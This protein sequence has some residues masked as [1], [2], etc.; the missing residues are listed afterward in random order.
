[1]VDR[2]FEIVEAVGKFYSVRPEEGE[3]SKLTIRNLSDTTFIS[4]RSCIDVVIKLSSLL[5][6][7][8]YGPG[9]DMF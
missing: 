8:V 1:M 7:Y 9:E 4:E 3:D 6:F 2:M 5:A